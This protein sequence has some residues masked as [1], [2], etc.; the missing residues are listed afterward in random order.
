MISG[1]IKLLITSDNSKD[2]NMQSLP[3]YKMIFIITQI[4]INSN[5]KFDLLVV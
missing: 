3:F 1:K 2:K 5:K 4:D